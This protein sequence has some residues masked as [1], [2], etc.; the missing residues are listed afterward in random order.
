MSISTP[1]I[2]NPYD[3][4]I[5]FP[6]FQYA[7]SRGVFPEFKRSAYRKVNETRI[8][9]SERNEDDPTYQRRILESLTMYGEFATWSISPSKA[10]FSNG[11]KT[12]F[13]DQTEI[14]G[15]SIDVGRSRINGQVSNPM[16]ADYPGT[17]TIN[18]FDVTDNEN[19]TSILTVSMSRI[20]SNWTDIT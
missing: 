11:D 2:S 20:V 1:P 5:G 15:V 3:S 19:N 8:K 17:F 14:S 7:P 18:D 13:A 10:D 4:K 12:G 6:V 16:L 9:P